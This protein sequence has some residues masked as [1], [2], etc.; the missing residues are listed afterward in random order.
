M[1]STTGRRAVLRYEPG[2]FQ[3]ISPGDHVVCA[4]SGAVIPLEQLRYWSAATQEAYASCQ[5]SV[6]A[7]L[8]ARGAGAA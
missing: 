5:I 7:A 1:F 8:A 6:D 2:S 4:R 3:V